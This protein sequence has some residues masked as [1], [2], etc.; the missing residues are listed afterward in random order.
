MDD[1]KVFRK[2]YCG[3]INNVGK[4]IKH[5]S[6]EKKQILQEGN[7]QLWAEF[8]AYLNPILDIERADRDDVF[9]KSNKFDR[10]DFGN[11]IPFELF[12]AL[13]SLHMSHKQDAEKEEKDNFNHDDNDYKHDEHDDQDNEHDGEGSDGEK[14]EDTL[15]IS[16]P[17]KHDKTHDEVTVDTKTVTENP[18]DSQERVVPQEFEVRLKHSKSIEE[19]VIETRQDND[20]IQERE[21]HKHQKEET[22]KTEGDDQH[23][24]KPQEGTK[25]GEPE[26]KKD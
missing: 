16:E 17:V 2:A 7:Q 24:E 9:R 3:A 19:Q 23:V 8:N 1:S 25:E 4:M 12:S 13:T 18:P 6:A 21:E 14:K 22:E 20:L 15:E 11:N 26:A 5:L 10:P